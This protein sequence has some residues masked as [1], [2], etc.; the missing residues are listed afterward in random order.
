MVRT[1]YHCLFFASVQ[2]YSFV[3]SQLLFWRTRSVLALV[4]LLF[5]LYGVA[6]TVLMAARRGPRQWISSSLF[7]LPFLCETL[8]HPKWLMALVVLGAGR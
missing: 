1:N 8:G 7:A 5:G 3:L 6:L 4:L 2:K